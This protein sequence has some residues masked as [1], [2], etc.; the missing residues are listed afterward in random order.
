M[1][2]CRTLLL[3]LCLAAAAPA[4]AAA[5]DVRVVERTEPLGAV[6]SSAARAAPAP[7]TLVGIHWQGEGEVAFRTAL[8]PGDWSA[9]RSARPEAEDLPDRSSPEADASRGWKMGNPWW[10]GEAHYIQYRVTGSVTR[11]RTFFVFSPVKGADA[12][13]AAALAS[14][15]ALRADTAVAALEADRPPIIRRPDWGADE[16]IVRGSPSYADRLRYAVVHHT[17]GTN[18][19]SAAQSAAIVRG[20]Q[21]YHVLSNGWNDIG[22]NFLVDKYGQIFEGRAGGVAGSVVGAHAQGFNTGSVGVAVL[23]SY[24]SR[25]ISAAARRSVERLLA[26][27]LDVA[28][29]NPR[30]TRDVAS[31]GNPRFP[32]GRTIRLRAVSGHRD[33]GYTSCPGGALYDR[34]R[35]IARNVAGIGLPKLYD[36]AAS[37]EVGGPVRFTA[38]LSSARAWRVEVSDALGALVASGSGTGTA[39]DWTWD[40]STVPFGSY[41]YEISAGDAVRPASDDVPGPPPLAVTGLRATPDALTPNGDWT[42]EDTTVSF[43]LSRRATIG[44]RV[45]DASTGTLVRTLMASGS[46]P[47]GAFSRAWDGRTSGGALVADGRYRVEVSAESGVETVT[48]AVGLVVDR[49]LGGMTVSPTVVS[50]NGDGRYERLR[51]GFQLTRAASVRV[52]VRRGGDV[53]RTLLSG[54]LAAGAYATSWDGITRN[55]TRS[56]DGDVTAYIAAE[57]ALGSRKLRRHAR[58]DATRPVVRVHSVR[59]TP[60]GY[61]RIRFSLSEPARVRFWYGRRTWRDGSSIVRDRPAGTQVIRRGV[62]AGV[63]RLRARDGAGNIRSVVARG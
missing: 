54:S 24:G 27:R 37:G 10:T 28:H 26:W 5:D 29:V 6:R 12:E 45:E 50:P 44:M 32:A 51:I 61:T 15:D 58:V 7:F 9:W 60:G 59:V 39:V 31:G 21:R 18:S 13:R 48:R 19:Y 42:G 43:R 22:Y 36:H 2:L 40:S 34:L 25:N 23:G 30:A 52:Q 20:I 63:V 41:T 1:S 57:T 14:G 38:R 53:L 56:G 55:G 62:R 4:T 11:L 33:T 35:A 17:A 3:A 47:A 49:T 8:E 46:R 16:T